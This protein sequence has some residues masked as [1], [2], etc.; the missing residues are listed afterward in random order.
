MYRQTIFKS[1]APPSCTGTH[2]FF[3]RH[4]PPIYTDN[5]F[6]YRQAPTRCIGI[7]FFEPET[8]P[9]TMYWHSCVQAPDASK[10]YL[11]LH[12]RMPSPSKVHRHPFPSNSRPLQDAPVLTFFVNARHIQV[13][14]CFSSPISIQMQFPFKKL[15]APF[16]HPNVAQSNLQHHK[17]A[18]LVS[19]QRGVSIRGTKTNGSPHCG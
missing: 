16:N 12:F 18:L 14:K 3:A 1:L 11:H 15:C 2:F 6:G 4:A 8:P 17:A 5:H 13:L 7:H 19:A 10:S 9:S